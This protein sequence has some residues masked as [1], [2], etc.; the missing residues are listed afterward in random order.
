ML[1]SSIRGGRRDRARRGRVWRRTRCWGG[2]GRC[3][4]RA[5][6]PPSAGGGACEVARRV[7]S[8]EVPGCKGSFQR[9]QRR[10]GGD[11]GPAMRQG[12]EGL[13]TEKRA[14]ACAGGGRTGREQREPDRGGRC[15][16]RGAGAEVR[17]REG[18]R[19]PGR[20]RGGSL[21]EDR[22]AGTERSRLP[23]GSV[24]VPES[25][26]GGVPPGRG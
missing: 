17:S 13:P 23:E 20:S 8:G 7:R 19:R 9:G 25:W 22:G 16:R 1:V 18:S 5:G 4:R 11:A 26:R 10:H 21:G 3:G 14:L 15:G 2:T 12:G 6:S 24:L